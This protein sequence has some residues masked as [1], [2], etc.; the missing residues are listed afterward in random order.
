VTRLD[1]K[2]DDELDE[3]TRALF[4]DMAKRG[5]EV[6]D[7]YRLL[8]NAPE[9]LKAWTDLAW[10]LRGFDA[11]SR[12]VRELLIMRT[13]QWTGANYEWVHHWRLALAAGVSE[14]QLHELA[15]WRTSDCFDAPQRTA[16]A[17][18]DEMLQSGKVSNTAFDAVRT[19]FGDAGTIHLTLTVAFYICVARFAGAM[20]LDIESKYGAVP[21]VPAPEGSSI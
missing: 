11:T 9:L 10:P 4:A 13:A 16:L 14:P 8:A 21:S 15:D 1:L 18:A 17:F 5:A 12:A 20:E 3:G 7:L 19:Q 2:K 6:P